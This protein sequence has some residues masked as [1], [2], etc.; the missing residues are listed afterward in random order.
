[1]EHTKYK[2]LE[3]AN[4][5]IKEGSEVSLR[6][7]AL[8]LRFC[9]EA[10]TYEKLSSS[11]KHIPPDVLD[12]W[13]PPQAIKA[14]LEHEPKGDKGFTIYAG[15][16]EKYG[17]PSKNMRFVGEHKAF[18]L[19]WLRKH[20]NK[21]GRVLH[22]THTRASD[23]VNSVNQLQNYLTEVSTEI[24][25]I[26]KGN[27]LGGWLGETFQFECKNC[28]QLILY[29]RHTLETSG[30]VVCQNQN[31][32][33]EYYGELNKDGNGAAF[34]LKVT[35][36]DCVECGGKIPIENRHI[37]IGLE[38]ICPSCESKHKI[39]NKQWGYSAEIEEQ[40]KS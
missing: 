13:Q 18:N 12:K 10:I 32:R 1:M 21:V 34:H 16:E 15:I 6:Y 26:L 19:K 39:E 3:R 11:A 9:M 29:G 20:Y 4:L 30:H 36:F 25:E 2:Y 33:A 22:F 28:N 38:F 37:Q 14:L 7:A 17:K 24:E 35:K 40:E 31:C 5:L 8:E 27:I 23:S